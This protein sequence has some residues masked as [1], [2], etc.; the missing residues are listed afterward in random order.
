MGAY[1]TFLMTLLET[2]PGEARGNP[3]VKL[4]TV[5]ARNLNEEQCKGLA[6]VVKELGKKIE[7]YESK[8]H[9]AETS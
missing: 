7:E 5:A 8:L 4:L 3:Q 2:I 9:H 6:E 1:Q